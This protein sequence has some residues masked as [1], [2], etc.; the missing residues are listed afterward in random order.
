LN[1]LGLSRGIKPPTAGQ[2]GNAEG[3][4]DEVE[5]AALPEK[6][7]T[8]YKFGG[9]V[10]TTVVEAM[11]MDV[12]GEDNAQTVARNAQQA[13]GKL[14]GLEEGGAGLKKAFKTAARQAG[15]VTASNVKPGTKVK[16]I[17]PKTNS[18]AGKKL[19]KKT[20][21]KR[22]K[23]VAKVDKRFPSGPKGGG[24]KIKKRKG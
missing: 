22:K 4:D 8:M 6:D 1:E 12:A 20:Q 13:M 7:E 18:K 5:E 21:A 9:A 11:T 17:K 16:H 19:G 24:K 2:D 14:G 3:N 10:T 15:T 23:K